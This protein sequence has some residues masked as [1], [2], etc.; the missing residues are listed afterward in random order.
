LFDMPEGLGKVMTTEPGADGPAL[1]L[2][3]AMA[4]GGSMGKELSC[5]QGRR[6]VGQAV[7]LFIEFTLLLVDEA[8]IEKRMPGGL[9]R[10]SG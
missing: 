2:L 3:E 7:D 5:V 10:S 6:V 9:I 8:I 1:L 4:S